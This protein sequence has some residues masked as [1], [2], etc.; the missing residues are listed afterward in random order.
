MTIKKL[1]YKIHSP[2]SKCPYKL[3]VIKTLINPCL[4]CKMNGYSAFEQ[5]QKQISKRNTC[6]Q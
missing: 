2:C 1:F 4:Q 3:G 6:E 5:F